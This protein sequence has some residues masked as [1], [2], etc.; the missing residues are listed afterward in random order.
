MSPSQEAR[1]RLLKRCD[2]IYTEE[3]WK[4]RGDFRPNPSKLIGEGIRA[5]RK[6]IEA[7]PLEEDKPRY[8]AALKAQIEAM[9]SHY[10]QNPFS[11]DGDDDEDGYILSGLGTVLREI[12]AEESGP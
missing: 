7:V 12:A 3:R 6:I 1:E 4:N 10:R 5:G 2:E 9:K 8:L 11:E